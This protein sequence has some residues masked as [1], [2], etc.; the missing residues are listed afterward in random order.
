M[1]GYG[2]RRYFTTSFKKE[3]GISPR[4]YQNGMRANKNEEDEK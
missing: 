2:D 4:D 1:V 3:I